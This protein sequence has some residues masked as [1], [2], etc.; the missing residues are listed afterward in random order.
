M[1]CWKALFS[2]SSVQIESARS[3][4]TPALSRVASSC[5]NRRRSW[6][7]ARRRTIPPRPPAVASAEPNSDPSQLPACAPETA[8]E[9]P[10]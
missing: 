1:T 6:V 8:G 10:T 2:V 7:I 9:S 4:G 5:V 3:T